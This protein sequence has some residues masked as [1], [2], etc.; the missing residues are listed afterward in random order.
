MLANLYIVAAP[1]G[2][3]KTSLVNELVKTMSRVEVSISQTT[4][5]PRSQE[6][7]GENYFFICESE[8]EENIKENVFLE[9]AYVFENYYGT[10]RTWVESKLAA[11]ID[12]ILEIDWQGARQV[13]QQ[14]DA[15]IGIFILPPS[16]EVLHNRLRKRAQ[17]D[18]QVIEK[19]MAQASDEMSHFNEYDYL[20]INDDFEEAKEQL[21]QIILAN[22]YRLKLQAQRHEAL[23]HELLG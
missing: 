19:R 4:R 11:G 5:K 1:S 3:G 15:A 20:V 14:F 16:R 22:R 13:K 7:D 23:I 9:Y 10:S 21:R 17:D 6:V 2:A 12:V 8:F 18:S